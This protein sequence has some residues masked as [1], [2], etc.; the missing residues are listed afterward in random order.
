MSKINVGQIQYLALSID[1]LDFDKKSLEVKY[2]TATERYKIKLKPAVSEIV[3]KNDLPSNKL[4]NI[5]IKQKY[6]SG[7]CYSFSDCNSIKYELCTDNDVGIVCKSGF[8]YG[9]IILK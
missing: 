3:S 8:Y 4:C 7:S 5:S 1:F 9:T 6:T 2:L